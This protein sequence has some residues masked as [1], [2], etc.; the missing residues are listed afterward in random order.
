MLGV[1]KFGMM[2]EN[3]RVLFIVIAGREVPHGTK[4]IVLGHMIFHANHTE[5]KEKPHCHIHQFHN[6]IHVFTRNIKP[7]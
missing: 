1:K 5:T 7:N 6:N 4:V 3:R 2:H